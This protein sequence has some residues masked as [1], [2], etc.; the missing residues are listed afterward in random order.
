MC[1]ILRRL[2]VDRDAVRTEVEK[3]VG[4]G[5][6]QKAASTLPYTPR[7]TRALRLASEEAKAMQWSHVPPECLFLGLLREGTGVAA[8]AL[9]NLGVDF[10][11]T[12]HEILK[13]NQDN[14]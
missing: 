12:R 4:P 9:K 1:E 5:P 3:L 14:S 6:A 13:A 10:Q 7:A 11:S 2:R 8:L